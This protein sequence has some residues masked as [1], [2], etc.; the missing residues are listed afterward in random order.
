MESYSS[1]KMFSRWPRALMFK[2]YSL[3]LLLWWCK[4]SSLAVLL[5]KHWAFSK[6]VSHSSAGEPKITLMDEQKRRRV[7]SFCGSGSLSP[8]RCQRWNIW[9]PP[10]FDTSFPLWFVARLRLKG[11]RKFSLLIRSDECFTYADWTEGCFFSFLPSWGSLLLYRALASCSVMEPW[12]VTI[13]AHF[14]KMSCHFF[15]LMK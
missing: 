6:S 15:S 2:L 10:G 14:Q 9:S 13:T 3:L 5:P 1:S 12:W 4:W 8:P 7:S 11:K